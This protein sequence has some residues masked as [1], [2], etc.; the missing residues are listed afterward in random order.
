MTLYCA[1]GNE[2]KLREFRLAA[3]AG[4]AIEPLMGI[5]AP[6]E[7]GSTFEENAAEKAVYYSRSAPGLLFADDSGLEVD[8][9]DGAPGIYSARYAGNDAANNARVLQELEN[10][11]N[12]AARFVSVIALA[13][14]GRL[15]KTFRGEVEGEILSEARGTGGFG[16]DPL[17]W[18]PPFGCSLAE[19]E[20]ERKHAVS[21]RGKALEAMLAWLRDRQR[22]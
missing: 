4:F 12:R 17:F 5:A 14:Q 18:Y 3:G 20:A 21:H 11:T 7:T 2:G 19:V 6:E 9:L 1:T 16:Y 22:S 15:V 13:E 10:V 8:A